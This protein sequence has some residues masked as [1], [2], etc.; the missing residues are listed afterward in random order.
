LF[1]WRL[2][3]SLT[4]VLVAG[5]IATEFYIEPAGYLAAFGIAGLYWRFGR[6]NA[7][8]TARHNSKISYILI[9]TAQ[10]ILALSVMTSLTYLAI[11]T[12]LPLQDAALL[13][14][15]ARSASTSAA[16]WISSTP[17]RCSSGRSPSVT[18][19]RSSAS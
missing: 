9:A 16:I 14:G 8:S 19:G 1:N 12:N 13:A 6:L 11:S 2:L 17:V 10:M 7:T 15:I 3:A 5:L 18:R 4:G